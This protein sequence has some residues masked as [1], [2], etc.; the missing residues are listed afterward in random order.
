M[1]PDSPRIPNYK[2]LLLTGAALGALIG[3]VI[4]VM[5][6]DV[7]GYSTLTAALYLG[8]FGAMLGAGVGGLLGI[9]LDRSGRRGGSSR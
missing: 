9:A 2:R 4:S 8:A 7:R 1:N 5:G 6:D 3:V